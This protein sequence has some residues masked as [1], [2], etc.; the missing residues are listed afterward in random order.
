MKIN[1]Q[2]TQN[3][4]LNYD[5]RHIDLHNNFN[6]INFE[7]NIETMTLVLRWVKSLGNWVQEDEPQQL[8]LLHKNVSY[9]TVL[10]RDPE[11][12]LS[13]DFS[14]SDITFFPSSSRDINDSIID[15]NLP[16]ED[17]DILYMFQSG[18][19][20]RVRCEEIELITV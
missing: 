5:S 16:E 9:L 6:F 17:D 20:I 1:F 10:S 13:E 14:L 3:Y 15:K 2:L 7:Y 18:Q 4:A 8:V 12:S 11:M 19:V